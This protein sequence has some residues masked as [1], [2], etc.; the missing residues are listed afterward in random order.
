MVVAFTTNIGLAKPSES[1]LASNWARNTELY[2]DNVDIITSQLALPVA[3]YTP[4]L[5]ANSVNP[6]IGTT[7]TRVGQYQDLNGFI[8]G[9]FVV[10]FNGSGVSA[11]SGDYGVSLPVLAD[12][13]FHF[14]A[15][16]LNSSAGA[17]TTI[18]EGYYQDASAVASSGML[19]LELVTF[20]G[21][22]YVRFLTQAYS[23]KG[24]RAVT[25]AAP[26]VPV[27]GDS[28]IGN[29]YYKKA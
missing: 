26:V 10:T 11:G 28:I 23:G 12:T 20:G 1:E 5:V 25:E 13:V 14:A 29:F 9:N 8:V 16:S 19:A 18:G 2:N 17:N 3:S 4:S 7:G 24:A 21:V 27:A 6:N 22:S 15:P